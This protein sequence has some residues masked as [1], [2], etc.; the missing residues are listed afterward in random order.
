MNEMIIEMSNGKTITLNS[1]DQK[2]M[3]DN[4]LFDNISL[5]EVEFVK[6]SIQSFLDPTNTNT[7]AGSDFSNETQEIQRVILK[8][9]E[10]SEDVVNTNDN[11]ESSIPLGFSSSIDLSNLTYSVIQDVLIDLQNESFYKL[12]LTLEDIMR[13]DN[14]KHI[15]IS[16]DDIDKL[17]FKDTVS[18]DENICSLV[19]TNYDTEVN[20]YIYSNSL[21]FVLDIRLEYTYSDGITC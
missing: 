1:V 7:A 21:D 6:E 13:L 17:L 14:T 4:S 3:F 15:N 2:Q 9:D 5:E 11:L 19:Q 8:F 16:A 20:E 12:M 18:E 10:K